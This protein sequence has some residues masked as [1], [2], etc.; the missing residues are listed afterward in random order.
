MLYPIYS[1]Y[2]KAWAGIG[3]TFDKNIW[4][5]F[6]GDYLPVFIDENEFVIIIHLKD[7]ANNTKG[8]KNID[9]RMNGITVGITNDYGFLIKKI[10]KKY[11]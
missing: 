10:K 8:L 1:G 9:I 6:T 2:R 7:P 4:A 11:P 5:S 3:E